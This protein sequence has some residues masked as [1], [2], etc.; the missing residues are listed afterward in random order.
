MTFPRRFFSIVIVTGVV[1]TAYYFIAIWQNP[2][3]PSGRTSQGQVFG[4]LSVVASVAT[5]S[6]YVWQRR[7]ASAKETQDTWH[8]ALGVGTFCLICLHAGFRVGNLF[9]TMA[10]LTVLLALVS[11]IIVAFCDRQASRAIHQIENPA[12]SSLTQAQKTFRREYWLVLHIAAAAGLL[13]FAV[14]HIL[15]VLYY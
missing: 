11:G 1:T 15:S 4:L 2:N 10:F 9:A 7:Y 8:A 3:A 12:A 5:S 13:T 6:S 14:I